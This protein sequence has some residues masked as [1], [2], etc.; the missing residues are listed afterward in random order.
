M[1]GIA[2]AVPAPAVPAPAPLWTKTSMIWTGHDGTRW[3]LT[4]QAGGVCLLADG[5]EGLHFP[6]FKQWTRKSPA[7]P[8]QTFTG[9]SAEERIVVLPLAVFEDTS[10][11]AWIERDRAFWKSMHPRRYG[12]LTVSA[13]G[14]GAT[15]SLRLRLVPE[16][17]AYEEDAAL[18]GWAEY[19]ALLVADQPFWAGAPV[20]ASWPGTRA[21]REFYEKTGPQLINLAKGHTMAGARITND[22]DEDAWPIWTVIGPSTTAHVGVGASVVEIPFEVAAGKAVVLDTDPKVWTAIEYDYTP[23]ERNVPAVY[24]NPVDRTVDLTGA[25]NFAPIPAGGTSPVNVA[26]AGAGMIQVELTPLYWRAW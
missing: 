18:A 19:I 13:G 20:R 7:I 25:V 8:G 9:A 14:T 11:K 24:A 21:E 26:M 5:V 3:D 22:G 15:R 4:D 2:Y 6:K 17:H 12:T 16:D 23:P 10:S 1:A